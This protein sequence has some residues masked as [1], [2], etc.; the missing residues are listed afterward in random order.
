MNANDSQVS[1]VNTY[2][3]TFNNLKVRAKILDFNL[4]VKWEREVVI[5]I[6]ED[7]YQEI[8][9]VPQLSDLTPVYF[10]KLEL[11]D[12]NGK[13]LSDNFYWES[14]KTPMDFSE[15]SKLENVKLDLTSKSEESKSEFKVTV[16]IKNT[17]QKLSFMNRLAVIRNDN[18]EE[19]LPTIWSDNF[20]TLLPGEE[21]TVEAN[22]AKKDL[23]GSAFSVVVDNNR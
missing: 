5:N 19:V 12:S 16:K 8:F 14:T 23:N 2:Y 10:V 22:I 1:V 4:K 20:I 9:K 6:G 17:T 7:R 21:K 3:K 11:L 18:N 13:V 15:L